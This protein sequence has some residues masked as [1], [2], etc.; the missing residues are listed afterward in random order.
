[1]KQTAHTVRVVPWLLLLAQIF[2]LFPKPVFAIAALP[3]EKN[4]PEV[5][6]ARSA[7]PFLPTLTLTNAKVSQVA[8]TISGKAFLDYDAEGFFNPTYSNARPAVDVG[9]AGVTVTA[10]DV[11]N[12]VVGTAV[13]TAPEGKYTM[14]VTGSAPYR[15]EF[16]NIPDGYVPGM[17]TVS[18][19]SNATNPPL[20]E[21]T[22][23]P[24][25][26]VV[27]NDSEKNV[28][29]ALVDPIKYCQDDPQIA[30]SCYVNG[31]PLGGGN[32]GAS[33]ALVS[34][35]YHYKGTTPKPEHLGLGS[36][37]GATWGLAYQRNSNTLFAAAFM[38]RHAGLGPLGVGGIYKVD[39]SG[40]APLVEPFVDLTAL[41]VGTGDDPRQPGD[42]TPTTTTPTHDPHVFD[43]VGKMAF[44]DMDISEDD[45]TL[46]VVSLNDRALNEVH[47]GL[48]AEVPTAAE[49]T[50]HPI[51]N[52]GCSNGDFR[53]WGTKVERGKV[54]VG[55]VCS[56]ETSQNAADLHAYVLL[57][58]PAG[59]VA[60]FTSIF[61]FDLTYERGYVSK[62]QIDAEW[63][64][65]IQ[66]WDELDNPKVGEGPVGGQLIYPQ[67][68]LSDIE[69]D[70]TG[71]MILG[72]MDRF[73]NQFGTNNYSPNEN[74]KELYRGVNVGDMLRACLVNGKYV[75]ENNASCGGVTSEGADSNPGQGPGGGEFYWQDMYPV[76]ENVNNG[77]HEETMLGGVALLPGSGE[78]M[79]VLF[80]PVNSF[81][82]GGV[83][84]FNST[85]GRRDRAYE[86][87]EQDAGG[88]TATFGKAIGLG[89]LEVM[90]ERAPFELG[91]RVWLDVNANGIQ[92]PDEPPISGVLVQL[93]RPGIGLDGEPGTADDE[94]PVASATTDESGDYYFYEDDF[95]DPVESDELGI[96]NFNNGELLPNVEY[97][98]R[99]DRP[100]DFASG[101]P[102]DEL[103]LT[104]VN[105]SAA[106]VTGSDLNDSDGEYVTN[107][108]GS[109]PGSWPTIRFTTGGPGVSDHT[110]DFG[111]VAPITRVAIG[112][113]IWN[114]NGQGTNNGI[115]EI[116]EAGIDGVSVA[117]YRLGQTPGKDAP[118]A[119]TTTGGGGFYQFDNLRPGRY[120][121][122][123]PTSNF[124]AGQPLE[125]FAT[126][127]GAG[128]DETT[129]Q[130]G[131]ENGQD[132]G[133]A[134]GISS[135]LFELQSGAE[136]TGEE[137]S[138]Y[139]GALADADV[140]FTADFCFFPPAERVAV[141]NRVWID[142]GAGGG[143]VDNGILDG[144]EAGVDEV[145]LELYRCGVQAGVGTPVA[146]TTSFGGGF[147][148]FDNLIQGSYYVHVPSANFAPTQPLFNYVSSTGQGA[149][150]ELDQDA[151]ENGVDTLPTLGISS[152]CFELQPNS[153]TIEEDQSNYAGQWD[154]D[155]VNFTADFGF[156][157]L[158]ERTAIGN[159][160]W[161]DPNN[162]GIFEP[163][164]G[165]A[166]LSGIEVNLYA[167]D[168]LSGTLVLSTQTDGDGHYL[169]DD[170]PGGSYSLCIPNSEFLPG[171]LLFGAT[172]STPQGGDVASDEDAD[173][174]GQNSATAA[175]ICSTVIDL[176]PD[177]EP[178][179]E[180][181]QPLY[182][183][184]HDDDNVNMTVDFG[185]VRPVLSLGNLIW[186]DLNDDG[187][188]NN[189]EVGIDGVLL[190]LY[191]DLNTTGNV[192]PFE[193]FSPVL[194]TTT[195]G[196][197]LYLF[198]NLAPGIYVVEL[199]PTNFVAGG[200]LNGYIS[201]D[202]APAGTVGDY[203]PAPDP[204][205]E[206]GPNGNS[207]D[208]DDNGVNIASVIRSYEIT[209][210][211]H[212]EPVA[213][214]LDNDPSTPDD[215]EN[216]TLDF[217]LYRPFSLG[218]RVWHDLNNNGQIDAG[219]PGL[220]NV[221]VSLFLSDGKTQ[222]DTLFT[223]A[224]GYYRFDALRAG[225]YLVENVENNFV[226]N[227]EFSGALLGFRSSTPDENDPNSDGDSRDNGIGSVPDATLG[228]RSG[229]VTL[230]LGATEPTAEIDLVAKANPQGTDDRFGNMTVDF[231]YFMPASLGDLVWLDENRNGLQEVNET[232]VPG[233]KVELC[234][235]D[236]NGDPI[237]ELVDAD[238]NPVPAQTTDENGE[239][240]FANLL[241]G[242]YCVQFTPPDGYQLTSLNQ[243]DD[244]ADSDVDPNTLRTAPLTINS[245]NQLLTLDA[246]L[247]L[248]PTAL[249]EDDS[250][251]TLRKV[252]LPLLSIPK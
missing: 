71:A 156:V 96:I 52:P 208:N 136:P 168:P 157:L 161:I 54:Y 175:G 113:R 114:D 26:Q 111:F 142:D 100:A 145:A 39:M 180:Q 196:G 159:L 189:G 9:V 47:I 236:E 128:V 117:L 225:S 242:E 207:I 185:F 213:E 143:G 74:D 62:D 61:D 33:D 19:M 198:R 6:S 75:L 151:D 109:P 56:A 202:A 231:G 58:D 15:V 12:N 233:V 250:L 129:D 165:E 216:L 28:N 110:H 176:Q 146:N 108:A 162:N 94:L 178:A 107:P 237:F 102:L 134:G 84:W 106:T 133:V 72:L 2:T 79:S 18:S 234:T 221:Q 38:K 91:N 83:G 68:I 16:T 34:F 241:P 153:E 27:V 25:V 248:V 78:V 45:Q 210:R 112:N 99:L 193:M 147:Y 23:G 86:I 51:P 243:G 204:D 138:N 82:S 3:T 177:S 195:E 206:E 183:G 152:N 120:T 5:I 223:D 66:S 60:N 230:G 249:D 30:T 251:D 8:N 123:I 7:A 70:E 22:A 238:G 98:I 135:N 219:E 245:G 240:L 90:C 116:D 64:P 97:E 197:G 184:A 89:D 137:Q 214:E 229:P 199:D 203:E 122:H 167:G 188:Y 155:N 148:Q 115:L 104:E 139:T 36:E 150:E 228:I 149:D 220:P 14:S 140:N 53:P 158:T 209:L 125:G 20:T 179:N 55:V 218:N 169:F 205:D 121:V 21:F 59:A 17:T 246:G 194:T 154:D 124:G 42:L 181:G 13:T 173:E 76:D 57:H 247:V 41:G 1:M 77:V 81:R 144:S 32:A 48:P 95:D 50:K 73:G 127:T 132:A 252:F 118:T 35:G 235:F 119:T 163:D 164:L 4:E 80:D 10:Y 49:I 166:G 130:N 215:S 171:S 174:N 131:D 87:F 201:S 192:D 103:T 31:D 217:G 211:L 141:G 37:M 172:S 11:N 244:A 24:R 160:V 93:Y 126:C 226:P 186:D 222:A 170:L 200:P 212:Q 63:R 46:W 65:W 43:A 227:R 187:L 105:D 67:P 88:P 101:G 239:Y 92:E 232:V 40:D 85:T 29:I 191:M 182:T 190:N 44:G 69:F 224:N